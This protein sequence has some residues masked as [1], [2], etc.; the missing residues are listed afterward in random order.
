[1]PQSD[2]HGTAQPDPGPHPHAERQQAALA[3]AYPLY[4]AA[5]EHDACGTGLIANID[6]AHDHRVLHLALK[7]LERLAHRGALNADATS[8][9]AGIMAEVPHDILMAWLDAQGVACPPDT[10]L[11]VGM[12]FLPQAPAAR[13]QIRNV[14]KEVITR[15]G[16]DVLGWRPVPIHKEILSPRAQMDC[17][18]IEQMIIGVVDTIPDA[19]ETRLYH[20]RREME[21][22]LATYNDTGFA[23]P[24]LSARTVVY[25]GLLT[26][27]QVPQFYDDLTDPRYTTSFALFHQRYSTNTFPSW[28]LAQPFHYLAHNGEINTVQGNRLWMAAR[29]TETLRHHWPEEMAWMR[30][31]IQPGGSDSTSLDNVVELL[32]QT[33]SDLLQT[34]AMLIPEAWEHRDDL[35]PD[36][37]AFYAAHAPMIAPWDGPAALVFSDGKVAGAKLDRNGLR[38]L[39]YSVTA[40]GVLVVASEAGVLDDD[41]TQVAKGRLGPGQMIAVDLERGILITDHEIKATLAKRHPYAAW[42]DRHQRAVESAATTLLPPPGDLISLQARFGYTHEDVEMIIRPMA[43]GDGEAVWSMG[44]DTPLAVLSR[45]P[46]AL[47]A[48]F[49]QRFAQVTNPPIDS[50]RERGV[51]SLTSYLG[52][53]GAA[54]AT[55]EPEETLLMLPSPMLDDRQFD[56]ML[57]A[58]RR[59]SMRLATIVTVYDA[60]AEDKSAR[61]LATALESIAEHTVAAVSEGAEL[62]ILSDRTLSEA[63]APVPMLLA[64]AAVHQELL[65]AGMRYRV[66]VVAQTGAMWDT[67]QA[68][69]LIGYGANAVHPYLALATASAFAG[70]RGLEELTPE[71]A[72]HQYIAGLEKG[73]LKIMARMGLSVLENYQGAQLFEAIGLDADLIDAYFPGTPSALGGMGLREIHAITCQHHA[74]ARRLI[75]E[76]TDQRR[77]LS[78]RGYIRFRRAGEYHAANPAI[79]KA[80]Q[81]AAQSGTAEDY[82][83]YAALV[84]Q[85]PA[86]AIRDHLTWRTGTPISLEEVEPVEAIAR[87]FVSSA[88]SVGSLSPEAHLTLTLGMNLL[89]G[90]SNT[91]EGGEDPDYFEGQRDGV[92]TNSRVKQVASGRFGVTA[93]YLAHA[94]EIEIKMAQGSKPGEGGQIPARKVTPHIARLRHTTPGIP[95]ISPPPH[96]DIYSIEDLAQ[97]IFDLKQVNPRAAVGVKLVA[98]RGVGTIAAGVAK[99]H[100]DYILISGHDGGTGSSPLSAIKHVGGPW[101]VGLAEAQQVLRLNGLRARVRLRVDGGLKTGRDVVIAALLGADEYAFGT[102]ALI[103]LGCDMARQCHLDTCPAGIATQRAELRQKFTGTPEHVANFLRAVAGEIREILASLGFRSLEEIIGRADLLEAIA[104]TT[105]PQ[106]NL[107]AMLSAGPDDTPRRSMP[108]EANIPASNQPSPESRLLDDALPLLERGH[109]VLLQMLISNRDRTVG[110]SMAG[111]IARRWGDGGLPGGSI[112]YHYT[113]SAGQSFGAFCVPGMRLILTGE[114]NDYVAKGMTGGEIVVTPPHQRAFDAHTQVIAGNTVLY[115]ATGGLL[116][117]HGCAGE[118]FAVRN[119]GAVAIAEGVGDHGCEYMTGGAA[120]IL[121]PTGRNFGAGM[122]GGVAYIFD[123]ELRFPSCFNGEAMRLERGLSQDDARDMSALLQH[124]VTMTGSGFAAHLLTDWQAASVNFWRV[125]ANVA[126]ATPRPLSVMHTK[127]AASAAGR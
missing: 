114:A 72:Q 54:F 122:S 28:R 111:E 37:R 70:T 115:G 22:R 61:T 13:A 95:L 5:F 126:N 125:T 93:S 19:T 11:A 88:M 57:D 44:D 17:P 56:Q 117:L 66:G 36:L 42:V 7:A 77:H 119:S 62:I 99:G 6:G 27:A 35:A 96:H 109:G 102:A 58:A 110:A 89:G 69:L 60:S 100:A 75:A 43:V 3:S 48:Y 105:P 87:R 18:H 78:D 67:H 50:L 10:S 53:R 92:E 112:T 15:R 16:M 65:H 108:D 81:H 24:S 104:D 106:L 30:P 107:T 63:H 94:E 40:D 90:R 20:A 121:G 41:I 51:M 9:G 85:R 55:A 8:D 26:A 101:E 34:F 52:L 45:H 4:D 1:M 124:Y 32:R 33:G 59:A 123:P 84:H 113:G 116:L 80:L 39:R 31:I 14:M 68:A 23:I 71:E 118:R 98:T 12:C 76:R 21:H 79:V 73:L 2:H 49:K 29:E 64:V 91:G 47:A 97:L 25:K 120:I 38:P 86:T 103:A 83:R 46:R 74:D 127:L 82:A